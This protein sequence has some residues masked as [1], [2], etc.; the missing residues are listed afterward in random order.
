M[1]IFNTFVIVNWN[2]LSLN[3]NRTSAGSTKIY[4]QNLRSN[5]KSKRGTN[6]C[7]HSTKNQ[8][9]RKQM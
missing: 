6:R 2:C 1:I 8:L 5:S 9:N 7:V 3:R 4:A